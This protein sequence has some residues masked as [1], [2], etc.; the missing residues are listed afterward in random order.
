[1]VERFGHK[2]GIA[3]LLGDLMMMRRR[4]KSCCYKHG[5]EEKKHG[6]ISNIGVE[7]TRGDTKRRRKSR[8]MKHTYTLRISYP[9][10]SASRATRARAFPNP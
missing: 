9:L 2:S 8:R 7:T 1:L 3:H 10:T 5:E 4:R 6:R